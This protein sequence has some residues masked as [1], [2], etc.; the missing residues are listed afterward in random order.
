M[1]RKNSVVPLMVILMMGLRIAGQVRGAEEPGNPPPPRERGGVHLLPRGAEDQL[2]LTA[3]QRKQLAEVEE[4]AKVRINKILTSEQRDRLAHLR[5]PAPPQGSPGSPARPVVVAEQ[6]VPPFTGDG[7]I[8][9]VF[10]GGHET[11]PV[12]HGRPVVLIAAALK[13]P[14]EVFRKA[15]SNVKPAGAG[16]KP[17]EEQVRK[18][19]QTLLES[20][21]PHGVTDDLLNTVFNYYRY[22]GSRGEMWRNTPAKATATIQAGVVTGF[23]ITDPGAGYSSVPTITIPGIKD[24]NATVTLSYGTDLKTNGSIKEITIEPAGGGGK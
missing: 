6:V 17:E 13:V 11:E 4:D 20:L 12:D 14:D 9:V 5:P 16:Q 23:K 22:S 21:S 10:S 18:N 19:K 8:E 1:K 15:F 2:N 24:A 3:E 7:Q